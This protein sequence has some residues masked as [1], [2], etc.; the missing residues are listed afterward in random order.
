MDKIAFLCG[1]WRWW[2]MKEVGY[3]RIKHVR[4]HDYYAIFR[5]LY[6]YRLQQIILRDTSYRCF[7][8][9]DNH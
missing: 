2:N 4:R 3:L 7:L 5:S 1:M 6:V 9:S 8:V